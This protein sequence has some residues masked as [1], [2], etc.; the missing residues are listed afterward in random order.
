[1]SL[2][3]P[4]DGIDRKLVH[5]WAS[6]SR[7]QDVTSLRVFGY[8]RSNAARGT[9]LGH[10]AIKAPWDDSSKTRYRTKVKGCDGMVGIITKNTPKADGQP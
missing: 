2:K 4:W 8:A 1:M 9:C 3:K 10:V 6:S 5:Q 7:L